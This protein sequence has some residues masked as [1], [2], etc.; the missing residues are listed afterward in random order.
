MHAKPLIRIARFRLGSIIG[1]PYAHR[2][3]GAAKRTGRSPE[4]SS[5][6][7]LAEAEDIAGELHL[8]AGS[9]RSCS[10][11]E[12]TRDLHICRFKDPGHHQPAD[13]CLKHDV[14]VSFADLD[15]TRKKI[16]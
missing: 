5:T 7:A 3:A 6:E 15:R 9:I 12:D 10:K 8:G 11:L 4:I 16:Y 13:L 14:A 2:Q 1:M